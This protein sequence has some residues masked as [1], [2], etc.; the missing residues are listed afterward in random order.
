[1]TFLV[2]LAFWAKWFFEVVE[3]R[4][5][6]NRWVVCVWYERRSFDTIDLL[7][8]GYILCSPCEHCRVDGPVWCQR[9]TVFVEKIYG[10]A[11]SDSE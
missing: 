8:G 3:T 5:K 7:I 2:G 10:L 6:A 4:S 1:M 9:P 11:G